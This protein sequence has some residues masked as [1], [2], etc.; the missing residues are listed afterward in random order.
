MVLPEGMEVEPGAPPG[1]GGGAAGGTAGDTAPCTGDTAPGTGAT[2]PSTAQPQAQLE[3][4]HQAQK[5]LWK[6]WKT[7]QIQTQMMWQ[8]AT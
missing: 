2:A 4:Q 3:T 6:M 8:T 1:L 5:F 7:T